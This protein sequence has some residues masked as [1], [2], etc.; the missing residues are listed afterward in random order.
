MFTHEVH[1]VRIVR[2]VQIIH[3]GNRLYHTLLAMRRT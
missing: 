3:A 1:I 2:I